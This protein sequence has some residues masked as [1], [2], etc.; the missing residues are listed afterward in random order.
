[1]LGITLFGAVH[2][3]ISLAAVVAGV[4][5]LLRHGR[6]SAGSR[7]GHAYILLTVASCVTG[8]F[9][10]HH[11]GFGP[12]HALA[13]LTLALLALAFALEARAVGAG[14]LRVV[15]A[16]VY[17]TTLFLHAIPGLTETFTRLPVAS[18]LFT[19]P[20]DPRLRFVLGILFIVFLIA[21]SLQF[22]RLRRRR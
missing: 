3:L 15:S 8:F 2:T 13:I 11:G 6:I 10:F 1:M 5:S 18:P 17:S 16:L 12:P 20:D 19:G 21:A 22:A 9:I 14:A 4:L 7:A